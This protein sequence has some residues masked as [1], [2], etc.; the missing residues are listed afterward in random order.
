MLPFPPQS[1]ISAVRAGGCLGI[2]AA[3]VIQVAGAAAVNMMG[4]PQCPLLMGRPDSGTMDPTDV[5]PHY[6]CDTS[7]TI[8][9]R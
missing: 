4:G 5:M 3:D 6:D 1:I 9:T 2:S 7:S 8:V